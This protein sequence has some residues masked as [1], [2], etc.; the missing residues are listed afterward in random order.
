MMLRA[1]T[2]PRDKAILELMGNTTKATT[3]PVKNQTHVELSSVYH[4]LEG[5]SVNIENEQVNPEGDKQCHQNPVDS[6]RLIRVRRVQ[7]FGYKLLPIHLYTTHRS[8]LASC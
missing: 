6:Q 1:P 3:K 4:T 5:L 7:E 2:I 8:F